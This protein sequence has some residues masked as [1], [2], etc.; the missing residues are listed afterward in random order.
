MKAIDGAHCNAARCS[1][2]VMT[3]LTAIWATT[4]YRHRPIAEPEIK[5]EMDRQAG[6]AGHG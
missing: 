6:G 4:E 3:M 2:V 1:A 5:R